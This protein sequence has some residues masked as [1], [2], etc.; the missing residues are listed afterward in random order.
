MS[1]EPQQ[2]SA[3]EAAKRLMLAVNRVIFY[4]DKDGTIPGHAIQFLRDTKIEVDQKY[5]GE[6]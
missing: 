4:A 5:K 3:E 1:R 6:S 2:F